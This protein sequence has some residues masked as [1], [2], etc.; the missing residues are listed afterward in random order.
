TKSAQQDMPLVPVD[1][2]KLVREL[3]ETYP[4]FHGDN[5]DIFVESELPVVLGNDALLT[6]CFSN[7]L[8][9]AVKFVAPGLRP[10]VRVS[11]EMQDSVARIWVKDKGIG[12]PKNAQERLFKMFQKLETGYE[13]TGIGLAIVRKV[14]E[15][16]GGKVGVESEPGQGSHFWVEL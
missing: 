2:S 7:L 4:N 8:G 1:L 10:E 12:I 9:N 13:G 11:A 15:R 16:M 5:A 6:Q 3:I 14:V